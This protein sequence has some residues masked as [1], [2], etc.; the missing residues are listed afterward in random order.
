MSAPR[1]TDAGAAAAGLFTRDTATGGLATRPPRDEPPAHVT[2]S[3]EPV[4]RLRQG[5]ELAEDD[6]VFLRSLSRP[7]RT[8][9]PRTL[10][11]K[12]VATGVLA[13]AIELLRAGGIDMHGVEAGDLDEMTARA[14]EALTRAAHQQAP[15]GTPPQRH[16][17]R[18]HEQPL[19][20]ARR[21]P[22]P[23][24]ARSAPSAGA[25]CRA[26]RDAARRSA[27]RRPPATRRARCSPSS[28]GACRAG[29]RAPPSG[30]EAGYL[31]AADAVL[32]ALVDAED[33]RYARSA[34]SRERAV[35]RARR[36]QAARRDRDRRAR[37]DAP[38]AADRAPAR[39]LRR[40]AVVR[41]R[42][43]GRQF[44]HRDTSARDD[45]WT[46]H[47]PLAPARPAPRR[48]ARRRRRV[49]ALGAGRRSPRRRR[50]RAAGRRAARRRAR[51]RPRTTSSAERDWLVAQHSGRELAQNALARR[52]R[53]GR[54]FAFDRPPRPPL[55]YRRALPIR[56][57]TLREP[58][59]PD[60]G[61]R[62]F[63]PPAAWL[64]RSSKTKLWSTLR[65]DGVIEWHCQRCNRA[66]LVYLQ[67]ITAD[68]RP[69]LPRPGER[70]LQPDRV[71][72]RRLPVDSMTSRPRP[73][74]SATAQGVT[75]SR[76]VESGGAMH[77]AMQWVA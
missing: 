76:D 52:P 35:A 6:V 17:R 20:A 45:A 28:T 40:R 72:A 24:R 27:R 56:A 12:F 53:Q 32:R 25:A 26:Q 65:R 55:P 9:Q 15:D 46:V 1:R 29:W 22:D 49:P 30:G 70:H 18:H 10:G 61:R 2:V 74:D 47:D 14:R 34:L 19:P 64:Q 21:R 39:P 50:P 54:R 69:A 66:W 77:F 68:G 44:L 16:P 11:S 42:G 60:P 4:A 36:R 7:A 75:E 62:R 31:I 67:G 5:V 23:A 43:G 57:L 8:G 48:W 63:C 37:A 33:D 38:R 59:A 13:A 3:R 51:R 73:G 41:R 58:L 71:A